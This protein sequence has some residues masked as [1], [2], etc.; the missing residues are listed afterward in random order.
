MKKTDLRKYVSYVKEQ[1]HSLI[2]DYKYEELCTLKS[3]SNL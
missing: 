3:R 2:D 1:K